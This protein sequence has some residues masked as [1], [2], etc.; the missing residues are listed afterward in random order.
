MTTH[1]LIKPGDTVS[2]TAGGRVKVFVPKADVVAIEGGRLVT[3]D[4][5][6]YERRVFPSSCTKVA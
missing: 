1:D 4:P 2:F 3:K 6:G 5:G